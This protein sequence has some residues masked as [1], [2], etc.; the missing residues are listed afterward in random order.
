MQVFILPCHVW[1]HQSA[2]LGAYRWTGEDLT[3]FF[4]K[5]FCYGLLAMTPPEI[6]VLRG[7]VTPA[8]AVHDDLR[9]QSHLIPAAPKQAITGHHPT[10]EEAV[11]LET[12]DAVF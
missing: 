4:G 6:V 7:V 1:R 9:G 5:T 11:F 2:G 10:N 3:V 8:L 12:L